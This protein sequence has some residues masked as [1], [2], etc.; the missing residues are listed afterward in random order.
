M[1]TGFGFIYGLSLFLMLLMAYTYQNN[2]AYAL[3]FFLGSFGLAAMFATHRQMAKLTLSNAGGVLVEEGESILPPLRDANPAD[4]PTALL[5][6]P[7]DN[8][9]V[10]ETAGRWMFR[11]RGVHEI[12]VVEVRSTYPMGLF[13]TWKRLPTKT[14]VHCYPRC[15]DQGLLPGGAAAP[16][17]E[18]AKPGH[19][20]SGELK[21]L[22]S[23]RAED[24]A[25][26]IDWR[27]FA[28]GR[29]LARKEFQDESGQR[30]Q[31]RWA[32]TAGLEEPEKRLRQLAA[33][34]RRARQEQIPFQVELPAG[35]WTSSEDEAL[36]DLAA[37]Q[38]P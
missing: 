31:L 12:P 14:I 9:N 19:Q 36:R 11:R 5:L 38:A 2:L 25:S 10:S 17:G 28:R 29:G 13:R 37:W 7:R 24:P 18:K 23:A 6:R 33:W 16:K 20:D 22:A 27:A 8:E 35:R 30:L 15:E 3:T 34:I 1:P 32:D 26:T 21:G 4:A